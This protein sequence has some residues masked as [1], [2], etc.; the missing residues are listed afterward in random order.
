MFRILG[1][2]F[3]FGVFCA[4]A[5]IVVAVVYLNQVGGQDELVFDGASFVLNADRTLAAQLPALAESL[6]ITRWQR[7]VGGWQCAPV[8]SRIELDQSE[9]AAS[10]AMLKDALQHAAT[11]RLAMSSS[12]KQTVTIADDDADVR[13]M[14][15]TPGQKGTAGLEEVP[16]PKAE[17]GALLVRGRA[18]GICGTDREIADGIYGTPPAG[19]DRLIIGHEGLGDVLEAPAGSGFTPG[20]LVVGI[21]RRPD[22]VP[23]PAC[24]AGEWDMCRNEGFGERGIVRRVRSSC[25]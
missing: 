25:R 15:V 5:G 21:V 4:L 3:G 20:D 16:D 2:L 19:E 17:D 9:A 24:A 22:P 13:A 12:P 8:F 10:S 6:A 11:R 23:C 18:V 7:T 1:W 14:M